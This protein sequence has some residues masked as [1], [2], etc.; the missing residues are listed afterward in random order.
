MFFFT[1]RLKKATEREVKEVE[2][3]IIPSYLRKKS[4]HGEEKDHQQEVYGLHGKIPQQ[5]ISNRL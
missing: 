1:Q 4:I 5:C 2:V 3:L